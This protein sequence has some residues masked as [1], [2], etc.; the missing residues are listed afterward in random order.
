MALSSIALCSNALVKLGAQ[1]IGSFE[2]PTPE[3]QVAARL[4]P[5]LRDALLSAHPWSFA[6]AQATLPRLAAEPVADFGAAFQLPVDFLKVISAGSGTSGRGLGYRIL[7]R[8]LHADAPSV[9]L[10]YIARAS[11]GDFPPFFDQAL[12]ARLA[13][14]LCLPLTESASRA[15][16]LM[17]QA[18]QELRRA[19]LLDSQQATPK[20]VEDFTLIRARLS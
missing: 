17:R 6:V 19:R 1:P 11:E 13:A 2:D 4:Y 10:T 9:T 5:A 14:E 15:E 7:G 8:R 16:V 20:R 12:I 3:A 18:E